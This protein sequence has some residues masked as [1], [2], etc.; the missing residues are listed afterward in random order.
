MTDELTIYRPGWKKDEGWPRRYYLE[1]DHSALK[2]PNAVNLYKD[3]SI[4]ATR[5]VSDSAE[6]ETKHF[7][8]G[9][10]TAAL[11]WVENKN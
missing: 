8:S 5:Q 6:K 7:P 1:N 11:D 3:G 10:L 4:S 9:E 2:Y